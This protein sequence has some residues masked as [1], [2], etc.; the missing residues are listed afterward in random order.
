MIFIYMLFRRNNPLCL[1]AFVAKTNL[2][3]GRNLFAP[4]YFS[5]V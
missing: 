3:E 2:A 5:H 4:K 1:C